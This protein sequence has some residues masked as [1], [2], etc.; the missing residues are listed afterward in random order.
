M[1]T[2]WQDLRYGA[3]MLTRNPGFTAVA[4]LTL[5]LGIGAN[6]AIFSVVNAVLLRP[7]PYKNPERL[8]MIR[9]V[10]PQT[11]D[12]PGSFPEYLDWKEQIRI[13]DDVA[14]YFNTA[15]TLLGEGQPE[16]F[17]G[18]R[19]SASLLPLLGVEPVLGRN[20]L[21]EE[22]Q[23]DGER[24]AMISYA[25]WQRRFG[26][27]PSVLGRTLNLN[28]RS[29]T[30]VGVLPSG[31]RLPGE[32]QFG[33]SRP[34]WE[35]LRL[36]A[37]RAPRGLHFLTVLGRLRDG[38][39]LTQ[40]RKE[41]EAVGARLREERGTTHGV[42][43]APVRERVV[44]GA[45]PALLVLLGAVSFVLL[46]ACANVANL[47]LARASA[48]QKEIAI[49][50]AV[51]ASRARLIRQFLTESILLALLGAGL[52]LLLTMW[53]LD[54]LA[55]FGAN[56]LPRLEEARL[57]GT[58]FA[59][60]LAV[61][62]LAA[63]LFGTAPAFQSVKTELCEIL[64]ESGR[65]SGSGAARLRLRSFLV[66]SEVALSLVLLIGAGLLTRSFLGLLNAD[67]GFDPDRVLGFHLSLPQGKY[68]GARRQVLFF[69]QVLERMKALPGVEG[70]AVVNH[71]PLGGGVDGG[72]RI[73][74]RTYAAGESPHSEKRIASAD[75]FRVLKIPLIRGRYFTA[76]DIEGTPSVAIIN[77]E[78]ARRYF[79]G[80]DPIG[81]RI[82]FSWGTEGWQEIVGVVGN[83]KYYAPDDP[84]RPSI[85]VPY[86]QR[87]MSALDV[88]IRTAS[89]PAPLIA[90]AREQVFALDPDQPV[91]RVQVMTQ[92]VSRSLA[93]QR[94]SMVLLGGFAA[95]AMVLA[96]V[97][98]YG[99]IS[100]S[101]SQ[102]THEIGIRMA[103]GAQ[104]RDI[105]K[106]VVGQGMVL[107]LIGVGVGLV[108]AFALTRFLESLLFGVSA[109]DPATFAGVALL[110]AAV[111]LLACYIPARRATRVDPLVALRYE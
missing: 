22:E 24:V 87:S 60:T 59:F 23:P 4:V 5:A 52:G 8:V 82:D 10:Q 79:P 37:S 42:T 12:T 91:S 41:L 56:W 55:T 106:L 34:I 61:S 83:I 88:V 43:L 40:G 68:P 16:R 44:G 9:D 2:L 84:M 32:I 111:A 36:D 76:Q 53:S 102:R 89:D 45:R 6:T 62:V 27:D 72:L 105:F 50:Q 71:R 78:L 11:G 108:G 109:T 70:A 51:G 94:L 57:D 15:P 74:G 3:R 110:L 48:R 49:R 98:I 28:G 92:L 101:V 18:V 38:L 90:A 65:Q 13:F 80:E 97:G 66:V 29:S 95:V 64:K 7:L 54:W 39:A 19:A 93:Q 69:E 25:L 31:F 46:I 67:L 58:V 63:L 103:L 20:F 33:R 107:T 73:E 77:E 99:V 17:D 85:Y 21:P 14:T 35:P 1:E 30:L 96:A 100:Y 81:K 75:Y 104:R 26:A 47:L 86:T